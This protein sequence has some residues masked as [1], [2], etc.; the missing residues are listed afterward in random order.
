MKYLLLF[1]ALGA[2]GWFGWNREPGLVGE[3]A[4]EIQV[5]HW[6]QEPPETSLGDMRGRIVFLE[7][8]AS[9]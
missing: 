5:N 3:P 2:A 9:W 1:A 7:F 6:V 8:W 4:P